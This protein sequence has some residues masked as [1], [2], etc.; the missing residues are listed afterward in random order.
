MPHIVHARSFP[1]KVVLEEK[2]KQNPTIVLFLINKQ[3]HEGISYVLYQYSRF[4]I[5]INSGRVACVALE[6]S[7]E[8]E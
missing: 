7:M 6:S 8:T 2:D 4:L 5:S 3:V 1:L